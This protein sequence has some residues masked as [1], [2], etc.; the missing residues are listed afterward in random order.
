MPE[1]NKEPAEKKARIADENL[2]FTS[3][4][5]PH[6]SN[7]RNKWLDLSRKEEYIQLKQELELY[8]QRGGTLEKFFKKEGETIL[9]W[10]LIAAEKSK[11]LNFIVINIPKKLIVEVL[12]KK[13]LSLVKSF[14][15]KEDGIEKYKK[16]NEDYLKDRC[17]KL[18]VLLEVAPEP[19]KKVLESSLRDL[20]LG[21]GIKFS[22]IQAMNNT[23]SLDKDL[24]SY[25][26]PFP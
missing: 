16:L 3:A 8:L 26:R 5:K 1:E 9:Y 19:A 17:E 20:D 22:I 10:A 23:S 13:D 24:I 6:S 15:L 14:L 21:K 25:S 11:V 2:I 4:V 7:L 12:E 18:Q